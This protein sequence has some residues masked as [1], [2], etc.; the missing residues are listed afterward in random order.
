V[1]RDPAANNL[2]HLFAYS[3]VVA[4]DANWKDICNGIAAEART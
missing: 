4:K 2:S 3:A 1:I